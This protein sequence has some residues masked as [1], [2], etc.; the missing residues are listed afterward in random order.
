MKITIQIRNGYLVPYSKEDADMLSA[1]DDAIY[2]VDIK[3]MDTRSL[4]Q[5]RALHL[6][7]SQI[8]YTLNSSGMYVS[9]VIKAETEW[10]MDKVKENIFKPVVKALYDKNSTTKLDKKEFDKII[11]TITL[12]LGTKGITIPEFPSYEDE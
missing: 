11:D 6:W 3:N 7:C 4:A 8:A 2:Q 5:N 1:L 10:N 9:Q 12:A